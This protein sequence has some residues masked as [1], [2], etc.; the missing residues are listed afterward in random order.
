MYNLRPVDSLV[1][2]LRKSIFFFEERA[3]SAKSSL[4][5]CVKP[6]FAVNFT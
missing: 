1:L 2:F 6:S 4:V 3:L 5:T